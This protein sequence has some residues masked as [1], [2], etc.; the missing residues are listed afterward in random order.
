MKEEGYKDFDRFFVY[1]AEAYV[2]VILG[3]MMSNET[4][5]KVERLVRTTLDVPVYEAR[6][7][8]PGIIEIHEF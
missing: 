1:P 8:E 2:E 5:K 6:I 7:I 3:A 4:K